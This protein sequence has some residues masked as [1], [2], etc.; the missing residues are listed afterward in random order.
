[1]EDDGKT[2]SSHHSFSFCKDVLEVMKGGQFPLTFSHTKKMIEESR[3]TR[4]ELEETKEENITLK[5]EVEA[6]KSTDAATVLY[7]EV[8]TD[9]A[10]MKEQLKN[11]DQMI[12][13]EEKKVQQHEQDN[14]KLAVQ[15]KN[16]VTGNDELK[17]ENE[18]LRL[19]ILELKKQAEDKDEVPAKSS[20][21]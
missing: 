9:N 6:S 1:V 11:K 15:N 2:Y 12:V 19:Q 3:L 7:N 21:N 18:K 14:K 4:T 5:K 8:K 16:L 10:K 17:A 20:N 13:A